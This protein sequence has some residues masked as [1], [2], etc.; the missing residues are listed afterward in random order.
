MK[1][2]E[3]ENARLRRAV[4][5]L[6]LDTLIMQE[7]ARAEPRFIM[8]ADTPPSSGRGYRVSESYLTLE[9][10]DVRLTRLGIPLAAVF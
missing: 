6:P 8:L 2:R 4:S 9:R 5:D 3:K 7:A 10:D 1:D